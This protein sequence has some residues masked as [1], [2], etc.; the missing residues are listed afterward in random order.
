MIRHK[1]S[2]II[3]QSDPPKLATADFSRASMADKSEYQAALKDYQQSMQQI[4][5]AYFHQ[6]RRAI[7]VFQGWDASGKGG[8]IRRL[9]ENLDPR[10]YEVHPIAAPTAEEQGKHY[11]YRFQ[12]RL[13]EAGTM[14][15]FDRSWYG[16]VLVERI[17]GFASAEEWQRAYQEI[18]EFERM[19]MDDD[20][21]IVKLFLHIT[22]DEQKKRFHERLNNPAKQWKLTH[23]D[24]RNHQKWHEY[25]QA[26]DDMFVHT[27]TQASPWHLIPANKKW[28][29]RVEVLKTVVAALS[30][31]VDISPPPL[32]PKLLAAAQTHLGIDLEE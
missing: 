13:P 8:A 30:E 29:A 23:E 22:R 2:E 10:G 20:V 16:R 11:L 3:L 15:I 32:C 21:R 28:F 6:N 4:Q 12:S 25:E 18:N 1:P 27:S 26:I 5:Q 17:E 14:A 19:L 24:I 7:I 9:T 31:G